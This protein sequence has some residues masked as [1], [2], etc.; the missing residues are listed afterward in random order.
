MDTVTAD[1]GRTVADAVGVG[2]EES[3]GGAE[4]EPVDVGDDVGCV[5]AAVFVPRLPNATTARITTSA[6]A[7][8]TPAAARPSDR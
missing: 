1:G 5:V 4:T 6:T 8:A 3:R 2:V 7:P